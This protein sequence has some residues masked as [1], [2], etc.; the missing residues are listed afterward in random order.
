MAA[1]RRLMTRAQVAQAAGV[2]EQAVSQWVSRDSS[3]PRTVRNGRRVGYPVDAV[4]EWLDNRKIH[5][6]AR[7]A[8]DPPGLTYYG[9]RFR[10][11]VGLAA[12]PRHGTG[13]KQCRGEPRQRLRAWADQLRVPSERPERFE[14]VVLSL[15][16][17]RAMN[18]TGWATLTRAPIGSVRAAA[19]EVSRRLPQP[20]MAATEQLRDLKDDWWST[21]LRRVVAKLAEP[22]T[23][24]AD[25]F[26]FLL[27]VFARRRHRS[28]DEY[29]V[30]VTLARLMVALVDP[31]PGDRVHDPCCGPGTLLVAAG[32]HLASTVGPAV[33]GASAVLTGRATTARTW[34]LAT[35]NMA[36]HELQCD[37]SAEPL[38][39]DRANEVDVG[40]GGYDVVLLN[41][42]FGRTEWSVP[43]SRAGQEWLCVRPA[44]Y[45][46]A[47]AWLQTAV[48]ALAP[49]GRAAVI[50]P[51]SLAS[52][53]TDQQRPVR[54]GM[55]EHGVVRC[56][57][58]LPR[59]LFRETATPV[60]VWIL[61]QLDD[62]PREDILLIDA[63]RATRTD[64]SYQALTEA[65]SEAVLDAYR[66]W[67]DG[68]VVLVN[69]TS[70]IT[71]VAVTRDQVRDHDYA[72]QVDAYDLPRPHATP[73]TRPEQQ[74]SADPRGRPD[75]TED[76]P[77]H[78]STLG[79]ATTKDSLVGAIPADWWVGELHER[80]EIRLGPSG[81]QLPA[82]DYLPE[83]V[84]GVPVV[85]AS[86]IRNDGIAPDLKVRVSDR[87]A[88]RLSEYQLQ[89]G[90]ILLVR[91]GETTRFGRVNEQENGLLMGNTC[92]RVRPSPAVTPEFL[93]HYLSHPEVQG[94]L[95]AHTLHGSRSSM[96][97]SH[98]SRL[99]LALPPTTVQRRIVAAGGTASYVT[100]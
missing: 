22:P 34:Q 45:D 65:G 49:G 73:P 42:P 82:S 81:T 55:V 91:I 21:R 64:G 61:A 23:S 25:T 59:N 52:G 29:L 43:A 67:L 93:A 11:A 4:A 31:Q 10:L 94:W 56:V 33:D 78:R 70:P 71:A 20:L 40:P 97:K 84:P 44:A 83:G 53:L 38:A 27:D 1:E 41:P 24:A 76:R 77:D 95:R 48:S 69:G 30:P 88:E 28:P 17:V 19:A 85:M 63:R 66:R 13:A 26:E 89:S 5:K 98:L 6:K 2:R 58:T 9:Q 36:I 96:N 51:N 99:P 62:P 39:P 90:D 75:P 72:L 8:G 100:V 18:P 60:T 87:T 14:A 92:I 16:Y 12:A 79:V 47:S 57:I 7:Q 15:L 35:L 50:M 68:S 46:T 80:C 32:Q 74:A 37:L 3:F 54:K 86:N